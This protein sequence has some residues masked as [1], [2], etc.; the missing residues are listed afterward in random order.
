[1]EDLTKR[2]GQQIRAAE[3][4]LAQAHI[5]AR[6]PQAKIARR[7]LIGIVYYGD[8]VLAAMRDGAPHNAYL[9]AFE[10]STAWSHDALVMLKNGCCCD[11]SDLDRR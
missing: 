8:R 1:M 6:Q 10:Q 9:D 3:M 7:Y 4:M 11:P 5:Q 2:V